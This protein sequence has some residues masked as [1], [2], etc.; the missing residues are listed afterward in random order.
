MAKKIKGEDPENMNDASEETP[1]E[2]KETVVEAKVII[3][4]KKGLD[5]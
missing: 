2:S 4:A 1:T 5:S 3:P